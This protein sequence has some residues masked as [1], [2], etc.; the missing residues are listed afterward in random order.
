MTTDSSSTTSL[1]ATALRWGGAA[2]LIAAAVT[3]LLQGLQGTH[4]LWRLAGFLTFLVL[5]GG[6]GFI[7]GVRMGDPKGAR[8]ALGL[9]LG[10]S[11]VPYLQLGGLWYAIGF[12]EASYVP[13]LLR[14]EVI[15]WKLLVAMTLGTVLLTGPIVYAGASVLVRQ[16]RKEAALALLAL[17]VIALL[18]V[19]ESALVALVTI[20]AGAAFVAKLRSLARTKRFVETFEGGMI[21]LTGLGTLWAILARAALHHSSEPMPLIAACGAVLGGVLVQV[22]PSL[23]PRAWS[24]GG[25]A[26][27]QRIGGW[28]L[29]LAWATGTTAILF[30]EVVDAWGDGLA[31][32]YWYSALGALIPNQIFFQVAYLPGALFLMYPPK[33][34]IAR[35]KNDWVLGAISALLILIAGCCDSPMSGGLIASTLTILIALVIAI[36]AWMR[37]HQYIIALAGLVVIRGLGEHFLLAMRFVTAAPWLT[38]GIAGFAILILGTVVE[39]RGARLRTDLYKALRIRL[40][41]KQ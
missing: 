14:F 26:S 1:W 23:L 17:F 30:P 33:W 20:A 28:C 38:L 39:R 34:W 18:P 27:T 32:D 24:V 9:G 36:H 2:V 7:T 6:L 12:G 13:A 15:D 4:S 10:L 35:R 25:P 37:G 40:P 8:T 29:F 16:C 3:F 21:V 22:A 41:E 5:L 31:N 11:V 19:R